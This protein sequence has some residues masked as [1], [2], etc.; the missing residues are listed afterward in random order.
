MS[1]RRNNPWQRSGKL[2]GTIQ[3]AIFGNVDNDFEM[4]DYKKRRI[5]LNDLGE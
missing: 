1:D 3:D 5:Y 4:N 2:Y